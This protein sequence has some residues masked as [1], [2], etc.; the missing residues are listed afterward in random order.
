MANR[1]IPAGAQITVSY[2]SF[3][4]IGAGADATADGTASGSGSGSGSGESTSSASAAADATRSVVSF[5]VHG[6][7]NTQLL[8]NFGIALPINGLYP[9]PPTTPPPHHRLSTRRII[10]SLLSC[11]VCMMYRV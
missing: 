5:P 3:F 11:V 8:I 2:S 9:L 4:P 7:S 10:R 6:Y 1:A